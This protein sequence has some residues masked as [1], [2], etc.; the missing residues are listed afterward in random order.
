[1]VTKNSK[2]PKRCEDLKKQADKDSAKLQLKRLENVGAVGIFYLI[3]PIIQS[4]LLLENEL[5]EYVRRMYYVRIN[6]SIN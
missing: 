5:F 1:M 2:I 4:I 3:L 6:D